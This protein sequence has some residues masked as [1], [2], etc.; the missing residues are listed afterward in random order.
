[1]CSLALSDI[2]L[3]DP[4]VLVRDRH[5]YLYG[6][7]GSTVFT[8]AD[9]FDC[10]ASDD[11]V[12]WSGPHEI[13]HRDRDFWADRCFWAPECYLYEGAFYLLAT[14]GSEDGRMGVQVLTAMHPLGPFVPHSEGPVTPP[15]QECLDGTLY[16]DDGGTPYLV[17]SRSFHQA[18]AGEMYAVALTRDLKSARGEVH[19]LFR[20]ADAPWVS[21]FP[22]AKEFGIEGDVYLSDGPF[23]HR[24]SSGELLILWSSFGPSG[25]T[26]GIAR[27]VAGDLRGP[28]TH[29][30]Q[31]L[32][33]RDGGHGMVFTSGEGKPTLAIHAPN[34]PGHERPRFIDLIETEDSLALR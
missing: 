23:A 12:S 13:F 30:P 22:F 18:H 28:W 5:Y 24:T 11:L 6:T 1:V 8:E 19:A 4:F 20:A 25:Y 15:G 26:V 21:P 34:A 17:F 27:S 16:F 3:R 2:H 31:P 29:D 7:R 32:F 14:F 10:Y 9:G 33:D